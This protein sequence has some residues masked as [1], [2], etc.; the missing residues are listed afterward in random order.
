MIDDAQLISHLT[1]AGFATQSQLDRGLQL[2]STEDSTLYDALLRHKLVGEQHV[3]Q[4]A[5]GILNVPALHLASTPP[6]QEM[7][8]YLPRVLAESCQVLPVELIDDDSSGNKTLL[9]AMTDPID[10]IAMDEVASH[11]GLN[12]RP[13]LV[14][15]TDLQA[16]LQ[17][18]Y[19]SEQPML[20]EMSDA[21]GDSWAALFDN[22][23]DEAQKASVEDSAVFPSQIQ[24]PPPSDL[25]HIIDEDLYDEDHFASF[26]APD[27]IAGNSRT[28]IGPPITLD[29]LELHDAFTPD[30]LE[31]ASRPAPLPSSGRNDPQATPVIEDS[32]AYEGL[33]SHTSIGLGS[34]GLAALG[35]EQS[36]YDELSESDV[37]P[38]DSAPSPDD[39]APGLFGEAQDFS[40]PDFEF[41]EKDSDLSFEHSIELALELE[42][43]YRPPEISEP[44]LIPELSPEILNQ[45]GLNI[46]YDNEQDDAISIEVSLE[47]L[48]EHPG[49]E[50]DKLVDSSP[51]SD[52]P[53][54][55]DSLDP[56]SIPPLNIRATLERVKNKSSHQPKL[57]PLLKKEVPTQAPEEEEKSAEEPSTKEH[58]F[59]D[60]PHDASERSSALGRIA[61]KR[62]AVPRFTG[63]VEKRSDR[64]RQ[65]SPPSDDPATREISAD[66][67]AELSQKNPPTAQP[68]D[69]QFDQHYLAEALAELLVQKGLLTREEIQATINI[70]KES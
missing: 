60:A 46:H 31:E 38:D 58:P 47:E 28:E 44:D 13:V 34:R 43:S 56:G 70:L 25:Y 27:L 61:V 15:P 42:E 64:R 19:A 36:Y 30:I 23:H 26:D 65:K 66:L 67:L 3:I 51:F 24:P 10:V 39:R 48:V 63:A 41:F 16:A 6:R 11:T 53:P 50:S 17:R 54:K 37:L 5:S 49:D 1:D 57:S 33:S 68:I 69:P 22:D 62:I 35:L 45:D 8:K 59:S 32:D 14:G 29:E 52:S 21:N 18:L 40:A 55:N 9:L 2:A 12:I 7:V 4:V 20:V